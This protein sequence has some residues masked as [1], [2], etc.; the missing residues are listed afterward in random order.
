M[1]D[2]DTDLRVVIPLNTDTPKADSRGR[3]HLGP[4]HADKRVHVAILE[5][6]DEDEDED[7]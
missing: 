5:V 2:N 1:T 7:Q 3:I 4:D 6:I